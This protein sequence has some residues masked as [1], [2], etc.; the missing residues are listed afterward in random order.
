MERNRR[1]ERGMRADIWIRV[2]REKGG[3]REREEGGVKERGGYREG[4][5]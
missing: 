2:E 1:A 4:G 3:W 5:G